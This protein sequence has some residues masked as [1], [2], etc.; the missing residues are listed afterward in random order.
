MFSI[1]NKTVLQKSLLDYFFT[2]QYVS[3]NTGQ[4]LV[5]EFKLSV[6]TFQYVSINTTRFAAYIGLL[7]SLHSNMFLVIPDRLCW[8]H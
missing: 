6:F 7:L 3:I 8:S 2:F 4:Q 5:R 1:N